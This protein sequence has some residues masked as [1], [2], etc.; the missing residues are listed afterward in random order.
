MSTGSVALGEAVPA[1]TRWVSRRAAASI[2][3]RAGDSAGEIGVFEVPGSNPA[4]FSTLD[5]ISDT[6][7]AGGIGALAS[8]GEACAATRLV[9]S[10]TGVGAAAMTDCLVAIR[11]RPDVAVAPGWLQA[12]FDDG[13][14]STGAGAWAIEA[15]APG[16]TAARLP[17]GDAG[18][19]C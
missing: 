19:R 4:Q 15:E 17:V 5:T 8:I 14:M 12:S 3:N 13:A 6:D 2:T 9:V 11:N 16:P 7:A 18:L 1:S 10:S